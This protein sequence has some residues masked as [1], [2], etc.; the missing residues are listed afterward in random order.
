MAATLIDGVMLAKRH[1]GRLKEQVAGL[2]EAGIVPRLAVIL[3]G[4]RL[5]G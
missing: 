1:N 2:A 4:D 5:E 3:V